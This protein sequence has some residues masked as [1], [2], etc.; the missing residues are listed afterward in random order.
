VNDRFGTSGDPKALAEAYGLSA[1]DIAL[2][3][4]KAIGRKRP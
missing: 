3:A 2:A 4:R 1:P